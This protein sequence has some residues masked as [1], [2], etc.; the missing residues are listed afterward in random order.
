M[1]FR[2]NYMN[3]KRFFRYFSSNCN[4]AFEYTPG[5][6]NLKMITNFRHSKLLEGNHVETQIKQ[7]SNEHSHLMVESRQLLAINRN[8]S[9]FSFAHCKCF[10]SHQ[11]SWKHRNY[12]TPSLEL[13]YFLIGNSNVVT[14]IFYLK[15][16]S[17]RNN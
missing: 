14:E 15:K 2:V 12:I 8:Q 17:K 5:T 16:K 9:V 11:K 6:T 10:H 3:R 1:R 4:L 13:N 7:Q